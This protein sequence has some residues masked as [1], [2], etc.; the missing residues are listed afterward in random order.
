MSNHNR[1]RFLV[2]SRVQ[3]SLVGRVIVHWIS[4]IVLFLLVVLTIE[5][6]L[7]EPGVSVLDSLSISLKKNALMFVLMVAVLPAFLYDTVKMSNRFAGPISRLK[8]GLTALANGQPV[9][10]I[11]FRKGDFWGELAED[12]NRVATRLEPETEIAQE[13]TPVENSET[14]CKVS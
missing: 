8:Y 5:M 1:G 4:F 2:D 6:F 7:R 13:N 14:P 10:K 12:F 3:L 11:N 9:E